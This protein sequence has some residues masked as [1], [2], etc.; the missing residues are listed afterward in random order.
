LPEV[1]VRKRQRRQFLHGPLDWGD[2]CQ[3]ASVRSEGRAALAVWLL[4]QH[5]RK[6][7]GARVISLPSRDLE[8]LRVSPP[9][10]SRALKALEFLGLIRVLRDRGCTSRAILARE[11]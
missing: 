8:L 11:D 5:R 2:V 9:A 1:P 6:L 4:I 7:T 3:V 10:K